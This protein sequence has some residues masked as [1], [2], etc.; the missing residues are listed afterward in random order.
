MN[1]IGPVF[2]EV[3]NSGGT[4]A[5][6]RAD[7]VSIIVP[8][9]SYT[10]NIIVDGVQVRVDISAETFLERVAEATKLANRRNLS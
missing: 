3:P 2:V 5:W 1:H 10:S 6:I 8:T 7:R 4:S 9:S